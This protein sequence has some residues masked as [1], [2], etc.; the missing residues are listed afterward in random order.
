[1]ITDNVK[2]FVTKADGKV[3]RVKVLDDSIIEALSDLGF[4]YNAEFS[5]YLVQINENSEKAN[6]FDNLRL[7]E[8]AFSSGKE[9]CPSEIFEYL[10]ELGLIRGTYKKISWY[11]PE[12]YNV[13]VA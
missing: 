8:V 9:W 6:F 7:L 4:K 13:T 11:K 2:A 3:I 10:R 12:N 1:M 5:E